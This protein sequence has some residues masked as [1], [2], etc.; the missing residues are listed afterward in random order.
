MTTT[1][2]ATTSVAFWDPP[3]GPQNYHLMC[4]YIVTHTDR[5]SGAFIRSVCV[6]VCV[7]GCVY[8]SILKQE[9]LNVSSP[10]LAG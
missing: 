7:R 2:R 4:R 5:G 10:N 6:C 9:Q 3:S 8:V 1:A